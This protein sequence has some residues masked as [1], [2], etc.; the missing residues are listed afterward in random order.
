MDITK[1]LNKSLSVKSSNAVN[2]AAKIISERRLYPHDWLVQLFENSNVTVIAAD[3]IPLMQ[4]LQNFGELALDMCIIF[5]DGQSGANLLKYATDKV[6]QIR[7]VAPNIG[8]LLVSANR[9]LSINRNLL[10]ART[11]IVTPITSPKE[12]SGFLHESQY[13]MRNNSFFYRNL[14]NSMTTSMSSKKDKSLPLDRTLPNFNIKHPSMLLPISRVAARNNTP[15]FVEISPQEVLAYYDY[16]SYSGGIYEKMETVFKS[17]RKAVD[18]ITENINVQMFLH[19]DHCNDLQIIKIALEN[20]FDSVMADGSNQTLRAN[21]RFVQAVK[22]MSSSYNVPVEGE[23]GAIDLRGFRKKSTTLCSELYAFVEATKADYVGVNIR[24]FHGCDY[25]FDRARK[26]YL[27]YTDRKQKLD[28]VMQNLLYSCFDI[29]AILDHKGYSANSDERVAIK[30]LIDKIVVSEENKIFSV[31]SDFT[32]DTPLS[33]KLWLNHIMNVWNNRQRETTE[34]NER[35]LKQVIGFGLHEENSGE[36]N[37]D[38]NLLGSIAENLRNT[39]TKVVL[40]GG[41]SIKKEDLPYLTQY[42][43]RRVNLGSAPYK[44][45]LN[46]LKSE[47]VGAHCYQNEPLINTPLDA[48]YFCNKYASDWKQR[49]E[50]EQSFLPDYEYEIEARFFNPMIIGVE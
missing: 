13:A 33:S 37:L 24:Q 4:L 39:A 16:M 22:Q 3:G 2:N 15:V 1:L 43:V 6:A 47:A 50:Q 27:Q 34:E 32:T 26:A 46:S 44:L 11:F 30:T 42:G 29:D 45:F 36:R 7:T 5:T 40:H 38:F 41:S 9:Q 49:L 23:V 31:L 14:P 25:G 20:G 18:Q 21:I 35:L 28:F 48:A 19:L 10:P 12:M 17:V 8:V